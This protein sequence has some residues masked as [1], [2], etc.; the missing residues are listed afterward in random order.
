MNDSSLANQSSSFIPF[1]LNQMRQADDGACKPF[2]MAWRLKLTEWH[3][4]LRQ[5]NPDAPEVFAQLLLFPLMDRLLKCH[6]NVDANDVSDAVTDAILEY[7]GRPAAFRP[8]TGTPLD[9]FVFMAARRNL[10]DRIRTQ[11][12]RLNHE[13]PQNEEFWLNR[14]GMTSSDVD[15]LN[16]IDFIS[17]LLL[18]LKKLFPSR[19]DWKIFQM[20]TE[21]ER[22]LEVYAGILGFCSPLTQD[23]V[24]AVKLAKHRIT[25]RFCRWKRKRMNE[26]PAQRFLE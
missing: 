23:Q 7:I 13:A 26:N 11:F 22:G 19:I 5:E 3:L 14:A 18:E 6:S 2:S 16:Q 10:L 8:D 17:G 4:R 1:T 21:C 9:A 24:R 15:L 12:R 25:E 20:W